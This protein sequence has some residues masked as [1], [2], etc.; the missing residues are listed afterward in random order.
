[1]ALVSALAS[2]KEETQLLLTPVIDYFFL[3]LT[4]S[5]FDQCA[6]K[7][8]HKTL[9]RVAAHLWLSSYTR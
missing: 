9:V 3:F 6:F 8:S 2:P 1:M 5:L 4:T 7:Q